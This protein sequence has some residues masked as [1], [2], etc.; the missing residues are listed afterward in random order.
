[1]AGKSSK[2]ADYNAEFAG[3]LQALS[4]QIERWRQSQGISRRQFAKVTGLSRTHA[5]GVERGTASL[6]YTT[7]LKIARALIRAESDRKNVFYLLYVDP[8]ACGRWH[9]NVLDK[10]LEYVDTLNREAVTG[11]WD[12]LHRHGLVNNG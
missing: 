2:V 12:D 8:T 5:L 7:I 9:A 6:T 10:S 1:M 4:R 3:E 11:A